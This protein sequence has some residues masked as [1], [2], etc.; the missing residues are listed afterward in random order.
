MTQLGGDNLLRGLA[1]VGWLSEQP[2]QFQARIA[3]AGRW[4]RYTR[5][6]PLYDEGEGGDAVFGLAEGLLD[7]SIPVHRDEEVVIHRAPPGFWIGD[8]AV[9]AGAT[10][11]ISVRAAA[12]S[13]V[14]R[15]SA[16][17][18]QRMLAEHPGDWV[19]FARLAHRNGTLAVRVLAE[20]L[21]LPPRVRFARLLLRIATPDGLVQATQA[22]LGRMAGKSRDSFRRAFR[23]LIASGVVAVEYG[24]LRIIDR[25]ALE[26]VA[27]LD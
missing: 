21:S 13:R 19:C 6:Q 1:E 24:G 8:S 20:A 12:D 11:T 5:G 9:M 27:E 4:A 14:F 16:A 15:L 23:E 7:I 10:R 22:E 2:A 17:A 3:A 26:T 18:V 25:R